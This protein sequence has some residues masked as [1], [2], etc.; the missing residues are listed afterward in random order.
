MHEFAN[1]VLRASQVF[2]APAHLARV[3]GREPHHVYR[4]IA[5]VE[6]PA[7]AEQQQLKM[8]LRAA[9]DGKSSSIPSRRCVD[10]KQAA[11]L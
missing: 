8:R 3:L 4:W 2:G 10:P 9:L 1:L 6:R 7:P 11:G 5:G